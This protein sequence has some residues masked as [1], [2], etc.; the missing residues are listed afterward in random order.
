MFT[1]IKIDHQREIALYNATKPIRKKNKFEN[2]KLKRKILFP[3][4]DLS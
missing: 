3:N 1:D 4:Q 2:D